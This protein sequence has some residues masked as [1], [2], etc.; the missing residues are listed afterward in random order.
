MTNRLLARVR[1]P[2]QQAARDA[3]V[4]HFRMPGT[5]DPDVRLRRLAAVSAWAAFL[6]FGGIIL[7]FRLMFGMFTTIALWYP[8]VIFVLGLV[9]I[10]CSI[11]AFGSVHQRRLPWV[12]PGRGNSGRSDRLRDH[13]QPVG[14][15][16]GILA[17]GGTTEGSPISK[18]PPAMRT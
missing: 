11:G 3:I 17:G 13:L 18:I 10:A 5:P 7:T 1:V 16:R 6:G 9:G 12:L 14:T 2:A 8:P 15:A 4:T